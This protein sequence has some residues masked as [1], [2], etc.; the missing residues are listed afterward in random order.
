MNYTDT[1]IFLDTNIIAYIFDSRDL[2][3]SE[4]LNNGQIVDGIKIINPLI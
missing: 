3:Y 2:V 4:D 1:K